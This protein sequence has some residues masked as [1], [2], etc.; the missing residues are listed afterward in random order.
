[1]P[2]PACSTSIGEEQQA[3]SNDQPSV[4]CPAGQKP[5]LMTELEPGSA[6][7]FKA[8]VKDENG[9]ELKLRFPACKETKNKDLIQWVSRCSSRIW[10]GSLAKDAWSKVSNGEG[11]WR[12]KKRQRA[13]GRPSKKK[14]P[15]LD[16]GPQ[17]NSVTQRQ[18]VSRK[19][20][21]WCTITPTFV[22]VGQET[23][24]FHDLPYDPLAAWYYKQ[25]EGSGV[26][27]EAEAMKAGDNAGCEAKLEGGKAKHGGKAPHAGSALERD[28]SA[29]EES[30]SNGMQTKS[31][32]RPIG[33]KADVG[34]Q[35]GHMTQSAAPVRVT[36]A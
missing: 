11:A 22:F 33:R 30:L 5:S 24:V 20:C 9:E 14:G 26:I 31:V 2:A 35:S 28:D 19:Q 4:T 13:V 23:V 3:E 34:I 29:M 21:P 17:P 7:Y 8:F 15:K 36:A 1:M 32:S 16:S 12:P 27:D 18:V 6:L 10:R 25:D